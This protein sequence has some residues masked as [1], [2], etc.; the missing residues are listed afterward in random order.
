MIYANQTVD[1][2][3][4]KDSLDILQKNEHLDITYIVEDHQDIWD[5][6]EGI[7]TKSLIREKLPS[8]HADHLIMYCGQPEMNKYVR[9]ILL[10]IGHS[11]GN[12]FQY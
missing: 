11:E 10:Q 6:I 9:E 7:V 4:L 8:P 5:G 12:I 3:L 1:D 2:I